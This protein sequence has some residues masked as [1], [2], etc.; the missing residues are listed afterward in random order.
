MKY[1]L[2]VSKSKRDL[3]KGF[4]KRP[5]IIVEA[6]SLEDARREIN[7][8]EVTPWMIPDGHWGEVREI[9]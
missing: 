4:K 1:G 7:K 3:S 8:I 6:A 9:I 2:V 5:V